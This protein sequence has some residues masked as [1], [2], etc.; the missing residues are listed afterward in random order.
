MN[1]LEMSPLYQYPDAKNVAKNSLKQRMLSKFRFHC[2]LM[3]DTKCISLKIADI[4][5]RKISCEVFDRRQL[6]IRTVLI[7]AQIKS[8]LLTSPENIWK[9]EVIKTRSF[10][11]SGV[12]KT[13]DFIWALF[14]MS[15]VIDYLC[16]GCYSKFLRKKKQVE[17]SLD[18][19]SRL[20]AKVLFI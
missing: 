9:L 19:Q 17:M 16:R 18:P 1:S 11:F 15:Q 5:G 12:I 13:D 14:C 3:K 8:I 20:P 10:L 6:M 4:K 2:S 7:K